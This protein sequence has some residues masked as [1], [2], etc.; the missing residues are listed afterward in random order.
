MPRISLPHTIP[1]LAALRTAV[2]PKDGFPFRRS[3][4]AAFRNPPC[5]M[6]KS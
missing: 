6:A 5:A 4:N 3:P 2:T 1:L